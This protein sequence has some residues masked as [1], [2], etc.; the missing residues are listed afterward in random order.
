MQV[1]L[2][3]VLDTDPIPCIPQLLCNV[4]MPLEGRQY[5]LSSRCHRVLRCY[6]CCTNEGSRE[7][8]QATRGRGIAVTCVGE[9]TA[10]TNWLIKSNAAADRQCIA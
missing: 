4:N 2:A 7:Q 3:H 10:R 6:V 9:A 5:K 1:I 8:V